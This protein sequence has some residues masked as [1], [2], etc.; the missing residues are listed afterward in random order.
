MEAKLGSET[1]LTEREKMGYVLSR[2]GKNPCALIQTEYL[3]GKY[4]TA[5]DMMQTLAKTYNDPY[6]KA[7]ACAMYRSLRMGEQECFTLSR[8]KSGA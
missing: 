4:A 3:A 8:P 7:K 2:T 1:A 6:K 5:Q